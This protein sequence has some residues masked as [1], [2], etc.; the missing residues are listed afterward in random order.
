MMPMEARVAH[1][2]SQIACMNAKLECMKAQSLID[3]KYEDKPPTYTP[4]DFENLP[5]DFG[6]GSYDVIKYLKG[7]A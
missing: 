6:L 3:A 2:L 4:I 7:E 1:V 5:Y